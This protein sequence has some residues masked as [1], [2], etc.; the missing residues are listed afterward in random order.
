[1]Q[2]VNDALKHV[3][4]AKELVRSFLDMSDGTEDEALLA[5]AAGLLQSAED[6]LI[7]GQKVP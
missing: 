5:M 2:P 6:A 3:V 7:D 1:M 4:K